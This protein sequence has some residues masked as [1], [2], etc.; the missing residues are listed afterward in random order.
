MKP[1]RIEIVP[2]EPPTV[3]EDGTMTQIGDIWSYADETN[4]YVGNSGKSTSKFNWSATVEDATNDLRSYIDQ[5]ITELKQR[6]GTLITYPSTFDA[7]E[8]T[9]SI[10]NIAHFTAGTDQL[11]VNFNQTILREGIDY[12]VDTENNGIRL[13]RFSLDAGDVLQFIVIAQED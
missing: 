12:V 2:C 13:T 4:I 8:T 10:P 9:T 11:L 3:L 7:T 5:Q 1:E 6:P